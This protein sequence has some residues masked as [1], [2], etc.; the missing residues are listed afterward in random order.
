MPST[1][2]QGCQWIDGEPGDGL[3]QIRY[4]LAPT[5]PGTSWCYE[6]Y[7]RVYRP[8]PLPDAARIEAVKPAKVSRGPLLRT[9]IKR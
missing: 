2:A 3:D 9:R 1:S 6:H 5:L 4:C 8:I 7:R